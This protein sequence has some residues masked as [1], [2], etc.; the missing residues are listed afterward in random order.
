MKPVELE[1][2][3]NILTNKLD[4]MGEPLRRR[5]D[6]AVETVSDELDRVQGAAA[7][8]LAIRQLESDAMRLQDLKSALERIRD[9]SYGTCLRC[10]E[11][12]SGKRL[13]AIPWASYCVGCQ[14]VVDDERRHLDTRELLHSL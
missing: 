4:N 6:I 7:R 8:E 12:I 13:T 5:E 11:R 14:A 10:E 1:H 2:F 9:G 3:R